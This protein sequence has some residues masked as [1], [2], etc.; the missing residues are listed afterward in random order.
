LK[1]Q[2]GVLVASATDC[3]FKETAGVHALAELTRLI[4]FA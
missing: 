4:E 1:L 2:S 3:G